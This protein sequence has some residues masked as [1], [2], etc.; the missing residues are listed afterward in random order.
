[1]QR[2]FANHQMYASQSQNQR[3]EQVP[4]FQFI[5]K[6][7]QTESRL[8]KFMDYEYKILDLIQTFR[9]C[10]SSAEKRI[11]AFSSSTRM[12]GLQPDHYRNAAL[13]TKRDHENYEIIARHETLLSPRMQYHERENARLQLPQCTGELER[14]EMEQAQYLWDLKQKCEKQFPY[15]DYVVFYF[16]PQYE[17]QQ[18]AAASP[19]LTDLRCLRC[20]DASG[21][22]TSPQ[23]PPATSSFTQNQVVKL[24]PSS[25]DF[26]GKL[27]RQ[28]GTQ[29]YAASMS[30]LQALF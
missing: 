19:D 1:M 8:K 3:D 29:G 30:N 24:Y 7:A 5:P 21:D 22:A 18:E 6:N 27:M 4:S 17:N 15:H 13:G 23:R 25:V 2:V 9:V 28:G 12:L 16:Q 11:S 10:Q 14:Q 26:H 20:F